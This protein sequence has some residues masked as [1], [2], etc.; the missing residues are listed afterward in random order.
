VS[1]HRLPFLFIVLL[2]LP[3]CGGS[4]DTS[5]QA[6]LAEGDRAPSFS[7]MSADGGK[8]KLSDYTEKKP[9]LLYFSMGPG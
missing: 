3:S 7:L 4:G 2:L 5:G 1:R 9:V 6:A 8:I